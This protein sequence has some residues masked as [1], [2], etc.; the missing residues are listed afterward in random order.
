MPQASCSRGRNAVAQ[1][2]NL[3]STSRVLRGHGRVP[4]A[5][6]RSAARRAFAQQ[7]SGQDR[8]VMRQAAD[9]AGCQFHGSKSSIRFARWSAMRA[10]TSASQVR[11]ST[12]LSLQVSISVNMAAARLPP[13]SLPQNVQLRRPT[14]MPRTARSAALLLMQSLPSSR[15]RVKALHRFK[16]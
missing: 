11:A 7:A 12:S 4:G 8:R 15:K 3:R 2:F 9:C 14:A 6:T 10:R 16:L 13:L 1:Y 5:D